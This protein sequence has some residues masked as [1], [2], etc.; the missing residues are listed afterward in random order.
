MIANFA[1]RKGVAP[2]PFPSDLNFYRAMHH[3]SDVISAA[4][5]GLDVG[6][7]WSTAAITGVSATDVARFDPLISAFAD[8]GGLPEAL[9]VFTREIFCYGNVAVSV[10]AG[11]VTTWPPDWRTDAAR[12]TAAVQAV[13]LEAHQPPTTAAGYGTPLIERGLVAFKQYLQ[14]Q[15]SNMKAL[16]Q[17]VAHPMGAPPLAAA[18]EHQALNGVLQAVGFEPWDP[19]GDLPAYLSAGQLRAD[20]RSL[21][22][23]EILRPY[24]S[25]VGVSAVPILQV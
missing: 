19:N 20:M 10:H 8:Y 18:G 6:V 16:Q 2:M 15:N 9:R 17:Y 5:E 1:R 4:I 25:V 3:Q 23:T 24:A 21:F 13:I 7:A 12:A 22:E 11:R 14:L